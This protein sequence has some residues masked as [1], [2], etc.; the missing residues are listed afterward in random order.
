MYVEPISTAYF[1]KPAHQSVCL[2]VYQ[3]IIVRQRLDKKVTAA[4]IHRKQQNNCYAF[5]LQCMSNVVSKKGERLDFP[6]TF[7]CGN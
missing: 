5:R 6:R 7:S 2:Y 4:Q 1:I 3:L